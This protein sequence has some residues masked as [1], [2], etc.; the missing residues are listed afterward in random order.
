VLKSLDNKWIHKPW[1]APKAVLDK[2]GIALGH[3]Y[4]LPIVDHAEARDIALEAYEQI[5]QKK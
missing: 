2:A 3:D 5:S 1:E 4:P